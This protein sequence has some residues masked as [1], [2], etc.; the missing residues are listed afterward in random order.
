MKEKILITGGL[1]NLGS[2][3]SEYF[4]KNDFEVFVTTRQKP[5]FQHPYNEI[6]CD[7]TDKNSLNQLSQHSFDYVIHLAS[8]NEFFEKNYFEE[9]LKIN[10]G[11]TYNLFQSIK[12][13]KIKGFIYFSTIHVYGKLEGV[14][15]EESP[16]NPLNDYASTHLFA[17][18]IVKQYAKEYNIP[19]TIFRLS[20]SYGH[21]KLPNN[22]KWYLV[23]ND[24]CKQAFEHNKIV[25]KTSGNQYRDFIWMGDIC[26]ICF[27]FIIK[28]FMKSEIYNL[29][30]S[31]NIKIV[32]LANLISKTFSE[33]M[34]KSEAIPVEVNLNDSI[35]HPQYII[36]NDK[37]KNQTGFI[38]SNN[39]ISEINLIYN[40]VRNSNTN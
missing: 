7:L 38:F 4:Y 34:N 21:P 12:N 1:G 19:F 24:L 18:Y 33:L 14:L 6:I 23:L 2:W 27:Y 37:I 3:I 11:G 29:S 13:K 9:A 16:L 28:N 30:S 17:E 15:T 31:K 36:E 20:N 26:K 32:D 8:Y 22:S 39:I 5:L 25:L 40:A 35:I 10:T